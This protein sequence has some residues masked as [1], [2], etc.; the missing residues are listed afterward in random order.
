MKRKLLFIGGSVTLLAIAGFLI[1]ASGIIP[2][3]ASSGHWRITEWMLR[4]SMQRSI[5]THSLGVK[6]P[7]LNDP[8]MV[9]QGALHYEIGCRSCHGDPGTTRLP[10][11]GS[12]TPTPPPLPE[13]IRKSDAKKLFYVVKHGIKFT[14]MPAWPSQK[15]DDEVWAMVAFL[16]KLPELDAADYRELIDGGVSS[17]PGNAPP[18]FTL[19]PAEDKAL[20]ES[21]ARCHGRDGLGRGREAFP[22]LAGQ[23]AAYLENAILAYARGGRHSGTMESVAAGLTEPAIRKI[24]GYYAALPPP[25]PATT[26]AGDKT[27]AIAR[28]KAIALEGIQAQRVPSCVECHGPGAKRGK[29]AY[30]HLAGQNA[31]YLERQLQLFKRE[32]RGGSAYA[33]LMRPV[34]TRLKPAQMRDVALYFESLPAAAAAATRRP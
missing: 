12:M 22:K 16:L 5:A 18:D 17:R 10:I 1:A 9:L 25:R 2:I 30:P 24:A 23:R 34:A 29:P 31:A 4:F 32:E 21:C 13:R 8:A 27:D 14:G 33:H 3:K 20:V 28:G 26:D 7:P 11:A 6:A 19:A 15:R